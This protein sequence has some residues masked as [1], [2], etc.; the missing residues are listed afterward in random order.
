MRTT[1][2]LSNEEM[3]MDGTMVGSGL[4]ADHVCAAMGFTAFPTEHYAAAPPQRFVLAL[5]VDGAA[6]KRGPWF[7]DE[8][9]VSFL[10]QFRSMLSDMVGKEHVDGAIVGRMVEVMEQFTATEE[11]ER[12]QEH[13]AAHTKRHR[14]DDTHSH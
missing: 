3:D 1:H 13:N 10:D 2:I 8:L 11:D 4:V 12:A 7:C 6:A 9:I 5:L 14:C